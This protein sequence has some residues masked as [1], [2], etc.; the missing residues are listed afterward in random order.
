M[1]ILN[2]TT[3]IDANKSAGEISKMLAKAGAKAILTEYNKDNEYISAISFKLF[4]NEKDV[5]I[6]LPCDWKPILEI[7]KN[8]KKVPRR[9]VCDEQAV[10]VAWRIIKDWVEAQLAIIQTKMVK[11]EEV[12]LPYILLPDGKTTIFKKISNDKLLLK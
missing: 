3:K 6:K 12:F 5:F 8:D 1:A 11:S 7:L 9:L 4:V 2:Y 10:R